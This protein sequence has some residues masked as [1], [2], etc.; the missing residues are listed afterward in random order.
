M[1]SLLYNEGCKTIYG[2]QFHRSNND[3]QCSHWLMRSNDLKTCLLF[4]YRLRST[5]WFSADHSP[6]RRYDHCCSH[7]DIMMKHCWNWTGVHDL[8]VCHPKTVVNFLFRFL[9]KWLQRTRLWIH[10]IILNNLISQNMHQ[11]FLSPSVP[12]RVASA[13]GLWVLVGSVVGTRAALHVPHQRAGKHGSRCYKYI[14][15]SQSEEFYLEWITT[16]FISLCCCLDNGRERAQSAD[17]PPLPRAEGG[18]G[19]GPDDGRD[20]PQVY[21]E[22]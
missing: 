2:K 5:N 3:E 8:P 18:E 12:L 17:P 7:W 10:E 16:V 14:S 11:I 20:G 19:R 4:H 1:F 9:A 15:S 21:S 22:S 6:A 13:G